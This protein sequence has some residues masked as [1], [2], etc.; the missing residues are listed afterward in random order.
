MNQDEQMA[1]FYELFDASLPRLGPGEDQSTK[2]AIDLLLSAAGKHPDAPDLERSRILDLGCGNGA[3]TIQLARHIGGPILAV[4]NHQPYLD[5]LRLRAEAAGVSGR[6]QPLLGD[7][8]KLGLTERSFDL[9]WSEGALYVMGF[10]QGL[11][12]CY[13]LL[14]PGGLMAASELCWL[15]PDPPADCRQYFANEY[16]AMADVDSNLEAI[17]GCGFEIVG[18]FALPE[19]AWLESYYLPLEDRLDSFRG[20]HATD[21]ARMETIDAVQMEID[22]YRR[23]SSYYGYIFFLMRRS[24]T[25]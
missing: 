22:F 1:F 19:S 2:K 3:Q 17:R 5:E 7:M 23:F 18:H 16:P 9:I 14:A 6:I 20:I 4:D 10:R 12:A 8:C 24:E 15:R 13:S 11:E 21:P 25:R